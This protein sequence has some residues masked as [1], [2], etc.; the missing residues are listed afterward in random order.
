MN[1]SKKIKFLVAF[2]ILFSIGLPNAIAQE[3]NKKKTEEVDEFQLYKTDKSVKVQ[4]ASKEASEAWKDK[5]FGMF[6]HWGPISQL[7]KQ[8]GHGR[9]SP[10][11]RTGGKPYKPKGLDPKIYDAQYKTF[12]PVKYDPEYIVKLAKK[13]GMQYLVFTAKH[14][15]G[16]SMWD[17]KVTDYDMMST[18]YKKDLLKELEQA[19]RKEDFG[20]GFYY[21][22]RDWH[23]PDCDSDNH[24]D[25]YIKFYKAQ[26]DELLTN[27]GEISEIWFD[28]LGPGD[29]GNTSEEVMKK[30]RKL[31]PDAMVN[32]RGGVGAD[33]YTPEH[34]TSYYNHDDYWEACETTT[35]QWGYNPDVSVK[36]LN[37]LME[38]LLYTWG[39]DGNM[40]LNIGPRGDGSLNP[41]EV[42]RL[43]QIAQWWQKY[44]ETSIRAS[45]GGAY[46]SGQWGTSTR[47]GNKV[48]LHIFRW[49]NGNKMTFPNLKG[50]KLK[51]AKML[52]GKDL[53]LTKGKKDFTIEVAKKDREEIVTTIE[54]TFDKNVMDIDPVLVEKPLTVD[55]KLTASHNQDQIDNVRDQNVHTEWTVSL[56]KGEKGIW[57]ETEFKKPTTITSVNIARGENWFP[58]FRPE[59]QVPDGNGGWKTVFKWKSKFQPIHMLD[60]PIKTKK[61]RLF[62]PNAPR[63]YI[64]EYELYGH[65]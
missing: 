47:K 39:N 64:A 55:A 14:H 35:S 65:Q 13:A 24:H 12:N 28:G 46:L 51:S 53:K 21:S 44:G 7:G 15:A 52:N 54:L 8:L 57:I 20:F 37:Q 63:I 56:P 22:P 42:E 50:V 38:I 3:K 16:F 25:R 58:K 1:L 17:S 30:I 43:E 36:P 40:L 32:D 41:V 49:D 34:N 61:V 33:F 60:K 27:Y 23:H 18:P 10:S 26:I 59:L 2:A 31:H 9:Y 62:I 11:H 45:R 6:I 4:T 48:Y 5:R 19:C 29:W